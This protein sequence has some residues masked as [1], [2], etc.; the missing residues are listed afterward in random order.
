MSHAVYR[1]CFINVD[2]FCCSIVLL[3]SCCYVL[4]FI[5]LTTIIGLVNF[6]IVAI[7]ILVTITI[8]NTSI[9]IITGS[10]I[11]TPSFILYVI[12]RET[13]ISAAQELCVDVDESPDKYP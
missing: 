10:I 4:N 1:Y 2:R 7:V 3:V 6:V 13:P 9:G 12:F 8:I 5:Y 11:V